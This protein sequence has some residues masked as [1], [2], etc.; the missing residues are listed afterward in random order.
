MAW[1]G[2]DTSGELNHLWIL[3]WCHMD[4][5]SFGS[6]RLVLWHSWFPKLLRRQSSGC[7]RFN[8]DCKK[9][10]QLSKKSLHNLT[11]S[12]YPS[13]HRMSSSKESWG[14]TTIRWFLQSIRSHKQRKDGTNVTS[15]WSSQ[16][17]C[18]RYNYALQKHES[19]GL[20]TWWR[21]R[22]LRQVAE[23]VQG[24]TFVPCLFIR[25]LDYVLRMSIDLIKEN[26]FP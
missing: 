26:G 11:D 2:R 21:Y 19:I 22:L 10:K 25:C 13:H 3:P 17:N 8:P 5:I 9:S 14:N 15:I 20:L 24:G 4:Y 23:V 1:P 6:F 7:C 18:Y 16:R 12:D